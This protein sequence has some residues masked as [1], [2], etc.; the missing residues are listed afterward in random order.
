MVEK[1]FTLEVVTPQRS[2]LMEGTTDVIIPGLQGEMEAYPGHR[3]VLTALRP[4]R[5]ACE[6]EEGRRTFYVAGGFAEILADRIV[7][8]A[9][10]CEDVATIEID[11][12]RARLDE[13]LKA[14]DENRLLP[15]RDREPL[16]LR[17]AQARARLQL[18]QEHAAH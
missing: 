1:Q 10:E 18:A 17:V 2:V 5:L 6:L 3:P 12:A 13:A 9:D 11:E 8:L 16:Q 15:A 4:G 14:L 7:V